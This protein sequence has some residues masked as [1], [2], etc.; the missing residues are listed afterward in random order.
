MGWEVM[1]HITKGLMVMIRSLAFT[2]GE[3]GDAGGF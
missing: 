1:G 3:M 2:L